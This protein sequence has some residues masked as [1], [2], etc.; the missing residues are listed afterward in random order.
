VAFVCQII[1]EFSWKTLSYFAQ[2]PAEVE[3][4]D[5]RKPLSLAKVDH[6]AAGL[7]ADLIREQSDELGKNQL[8]DAVAQNITRGGNSDTELDGNTRGNGE[9]VLD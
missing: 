4:K 3:E 2:H 8:A 6:L 9:V 5:R 7:L 1:T